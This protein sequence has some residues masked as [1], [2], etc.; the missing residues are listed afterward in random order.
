[1]GQAPRKRKQRR[2]WFKGIC[3][4]AITL[5][6]SRHSLYKVLAGKRPGRSL[7]ARYRELKVEQEAPK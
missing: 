4:D 1:M 5:G 3:A 2:Y 7:T 6:V